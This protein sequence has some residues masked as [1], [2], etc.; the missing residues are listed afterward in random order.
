MEKS[1]KEFV[2][3]D[4]EEKPHNTKWM[5]EIGANAAVN[6][7]RHEGFEG[8]IAIT[9]TMWEKIR[10]SRCRKSSR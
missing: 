9:P 5:K 6:D 1:T 2:E 4:I 7:E 8:I 10:T 3:Y